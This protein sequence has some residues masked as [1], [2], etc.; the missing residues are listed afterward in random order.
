MAY[1]PGD[2]HFR[3]ADRPAHIL[4]DIRNKTGEPQTFKFDKI[5]N[6]SSAT[7]TA[8]LSA[9]STSGLPVQFYVESGPALIDG[10]TLRLLPVP[11]RS[12][13]PVRVIVSAY[14]WGRV[15]AEPVQSAG[16]E[17][18]EFFIER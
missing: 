13:Y 5:P 6:V 11:P 12:R 3:S 9:T 1:D 15:G 14:Q 8:P 16:P 18:Q 10:N 17:T 7:A 4:I 2:A